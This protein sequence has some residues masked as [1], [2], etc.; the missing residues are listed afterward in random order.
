MLYYKE[1]IVEMR[2][3]IYIFL[4]VRTT[5]CITLNRKVRYFII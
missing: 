2:K 1:G 4:I 5:K 3:N